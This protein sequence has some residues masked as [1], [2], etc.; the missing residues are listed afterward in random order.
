[1]YI[2]HNVPIYKKHNI[3]YYVRIMNYLL[4]IIV[5]ANT[6]NLIHHVFVVRYQIIYL[7]Y[8]LLIL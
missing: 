1:M 5:F 7:A 8:W 2:V 4:I 6:Q 3:I